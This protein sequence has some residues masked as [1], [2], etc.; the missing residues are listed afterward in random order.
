ADV[1]RPPGSTAHIQ[2]LDQPGHCAP[3]VPVDVGADLDD[4]LP[5]GDPKLVEVRGDPIRSILHLG[6]YLLRSL[7]VV[8]GDGETLLLYPHTRQMVDLVAHLRGRPMEIRPEPL[9]LHLP[10]AVGP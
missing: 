8:D 9:P 2:D 5:A 6:R 1:E 3:L 4:L 10:K 7:P